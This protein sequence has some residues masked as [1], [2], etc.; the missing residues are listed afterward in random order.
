MIAVSRWLEEGGA[1]NDVVVWA[2]PF[3]DDWPRAWASC[4]RGDWLL[5]IAA[6]AGTDPRKIVAA[7]CACARFALEY[8]PDTEIRPRAAVDAAEGWVDGADTPALR[9]QLAADVEAAID[10]APDPAVAAAATAALAALRSVESTDDAS[11]AV[12]SAVQAALLDA[13]D[14]ALMSAMAYAHSVCV[15]LVREHVGVPEI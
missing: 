6:R 5:A 14:C 9:V 12:T 1:Q 15:D 2:V 10:A 8:L 4:P 3:G 13:G 7:A 11:F